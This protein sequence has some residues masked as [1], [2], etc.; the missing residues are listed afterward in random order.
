MTTRGVDFEARYGLPLGFGAFGSDTSR[1]DL[2]FSGTRLI[3]FDYNPLAAIP[4]LTIDCAG[5]FGQT[6]GNPYAKWRLSTRATY[7]TGPM[8]VSVL[9]RHLSAVKD[10]DSATTYAVERI[11]AYDYFD[12]T[13]AFRIKD[14]FTWSV[15]VNNLFDKQP[16]ILGDNQQQANTYPSTY[17]PY[18]RAFFVSTNLKF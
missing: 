8:T 17:D 12:L 6:C 10:D 9:Y 1:L 13:A 2:R 15:G 5:K 4:D 11:K 14:G 16:P 18:G 3:A 7:S